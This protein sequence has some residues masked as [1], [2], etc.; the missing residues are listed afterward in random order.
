MKKYEVIVIDPDGYSTSMFIKCNS[1][2]KI[3]DHTIKVDGREIEFDNERVY[4]IR[5]IKFE[6]LRHEN[7]MF[8]GWKCLN[9]KSHNTHEEGA[10]DKKEI[11]CK[12]C[13]ERQK[14]YGYGGY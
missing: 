1:V 11:V 8:K 13:N 5:L 7:R 4:P 9:C 14:F 2:K 6:A 12:D 10:G 3:N